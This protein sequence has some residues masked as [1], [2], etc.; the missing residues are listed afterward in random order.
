MRG[1]SGRIV[2]YSHDTLGFGHLRRNLMLAARLKALDPAP[3]VL[4]IAGTAEAGAFDLPE[5]VD[6]MTLPAYAKQSCGAYKPRHLSMDLA[7]LRDLRARI[8]RTALKRMRPDLFVVDN[9]PMGAQGELE[10]A[11]RWLA[12]EQVGRRVLGLRDV[13]DDRRTVRTQWLRERSVEAVNAFYTD[14]WVYGDPAIHDPVA[15]YGLAGAIRAEVRHT[16]Y[17]LRPAPAAPAGTSAP[18]ALCTVGGGRDGAALCEAFLGAPLPPGMRGVVVTGSQLDEAARA[19]LEAAAARPDMELRRFVPDLM[20]LLAGAERVVTMGGY[21]TV[22]EVLRLGLPAL[23]VPRVRPRR[24]QLVRA[25]RFAA[26]GLV[27]MLHPDRLSPTALGDWLAMP[28]RPAKADAVD[29]QGLD[30]MAE[31]ATDAL[32]RAPRPILAA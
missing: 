1:H 5:G 18:Y 19:R 32:D 17:L 7:E 9:V 23:V 24:E 11:L 14:V 25:E 12:R 21:N 3:E 22:C 20:P 4:L 29:T 31:F 10:P 13:L 6:L 28:M 16:G 15:E 2:L 27:D 8:I 26:L 30:R